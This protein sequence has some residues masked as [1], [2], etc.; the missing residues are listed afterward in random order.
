MTSER[1]QRLR[2]YVERLGAMSLGEVMHRAVEAVKRATWRKSKIGWSHFSTVG[3][4]PLV[5]LSFLRLRLARAYDFAAK[6]R[7]VESVR[8]T[9]SGDLELMGQRWP[10]SDSTLWRQGRPPPTYWLI[11]PVGRGAWPGTDSY[12]FAIDYRST[13]PGC[14][15]LKYVCEL[16]RWQFLHPIAVNIARTSNAALRRWAFRLLASW[17]DAHP[18]F[19]TVNWIS[20]IEL[21]LRLVSLALLVSA[22]SPPELTSAERTLARRLIAAHGYWIYRFPSL[23]SSANNHLV[24]EGLGLYIAGTLVPDLPEAKAWAHRGR[25]ILERET[26]K[27]IFADGVGTEQSPTYQAFTME[28]VAFGALIAKSIGE[29][30]PQPVLERLALGAEYL[31]WLMDDFGRTPAIGDDDEGRI[32]AQ[33]PDREQRYVASVVAAVAGLMRRPDLAPPGYD[34]HIRNVLFEAPP[35]KPHKAAGMHIF[36][37]GGYTAIRE[38]MGGA[39]VH[40]LFDHGPLGY[41]S[42]AAHGH[43]DA[44]ALWLTVDDQPV[45]VDA[46]T[47]LY[48]T[49]RQTRDR[50]RESGAHNTLQVAGQSQSRVSGTFIWSSKATA[51]LAAYSPWPDWSI[52]G[53]HDGYARRYGVI[54]VRRVAKDQEGFTVEDHFRSRGRQ[55][56]P[57]TLHF[58]CHPDIKVSVA[59]GSITLTRNTKP[60][61]RLVPPPGFGVQVVTGEQGSGRGWYSACF[62]ELTPAPMIVLSGRMQD[63]GI[64]TRAVIVP[65]DPKS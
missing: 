9:L 4:G 23:Y 16:N 12:C 60:I 56:L 21:S 61:V 32:I 27:Q 14:G 63:D 46:G 30:F 37:A 1:V 58:L 39:R 18:P 5:D 35:A 24:L 41:L 64:V 50:L 20:G 36:A 51:H 34:P 26:L 11:D 44:L 48:Y 40:L 2:F 15:D 7:I 65:A 19:R 52:T 53:E 13:P 38:I 25:T 3:D 6:Q 43:A 31:G 28:A 33:P 54:H 59:S 57:V 55:R 22:S 49:G 29:P 8:R 62:G 17:A 10:L 47:Y 45:F 42:L